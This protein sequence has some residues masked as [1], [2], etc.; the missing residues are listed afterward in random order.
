LIC[1]NLG[2][3]IQISIEENNK[4]NEKL[5]KSSSLNRDES[6]IKLIGFQRVFNEY[7]VFCFNNGLLEITFDECTQTIMKISIHEKKIFSIDIQESFE[8][9][10]ENLKFI[11]LV[12][13]KSKGKTN[14]LY[15]TLMKSDIEL[16]KQKKIDGEQN[17]IKSPISYPISLNF[18]TTDSYIKDKSEIKKSSLSI[19]WISENIV[20]KI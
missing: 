8:N 2:S 9:K 19:K 7:Y 1:D 12:K 4:F 5:R 14:L 18:Q 11:A 6:K 17:L 20:N 15:F 3:V 10:V 13:E 16:Y